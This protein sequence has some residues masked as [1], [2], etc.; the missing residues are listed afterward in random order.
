MQADAGQGLVVGD[1]DT[2][3]GTG[4]RGAG[5]GHVVRDRDMW[6]GTGTRGEGQG[7]TIGDWAEPVIRQNL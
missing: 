5:Q 3:W 1:R 6:C 4:T 2:W 7:L